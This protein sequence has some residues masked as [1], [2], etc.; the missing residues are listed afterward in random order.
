M[1]NTKN[2]NIKAEKNNSG[3]I[4]RKKNTKKEKKQSLLLEENL[5]IIK[6]ESGSELPEAP[7]DIEDNSDF[8]KEVKKFEKTHLHAKLKRVFIL[9]GKPKIKKTEELDS[10]TLKEEFIKL[11]ALLD[12]KRIIVHFQ[13]E[14]PLEEKYR[15]ITEEIFS[16]QVEDIKDTNLH[17]NFI[18]EEFHPE[19]D[20]E[21]E[22]DF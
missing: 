4:V 17:I 7:E 19:L 1:S 9:L 22:E 15:F 12:E 13:N 6:R 18:Y 5:E 14:Y 11:I 10:T 8:I 2:K 3:K 16:Q 21:E 20:E